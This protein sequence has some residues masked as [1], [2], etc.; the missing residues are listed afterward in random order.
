MVPNDFTASQGTYI[1]VV[2]IAY[3]DIDGEAVVYRFNEDNA[4]WQEISWTWSTMWADIGWLLPNGIIPGKEY[5]Y[6][7]RL[8]SDG[9]G[10]SEYSDEITGYA[11]RGNPVEI[12]SIER[13]IEG[14]DLQIKINWTNPNDLLEI[15]N[16]QNICYD[17]YRAE[18][19]DYSDFSEIKT[20]EEAVYNTNDI[21]DHWSYSDDDWLEPSKS[22]TY[23][24]VT[25][26]LYD[27]VDGNG[28]YR[29]YVEYSVDGEPADDGGSG[30][31]NGGN[32]VVE[33]TTTDLGQVL[34][35]SPG[36]VSDIEE[37]MVD[38]TLYLG[39]ITDASLYGKPALYRLNGSSW[40]N[41]WGS[42]PDVEYGEINFA[43]S[44]AGSYLAGVRDSLGVFHWDGAS[45][46][47]N[48]TPDNLGQDDSPAAISIEVLNNELYMAIEQHPQYDLQ[49]LK[50]NGS[51]WD[52]ISSN[53]NGI[54]ASG[55][56]Y[57]PKLDNINGT[58]YLHYLIDDVLY[59]RH[60]EGTGWASDLV[61]E[62][63]WLSDIELVKSGSQ[64]YFSC[65]SAST[66]FDGGVYR[67]DNAT[68]VTNLIPE[69]HEE[70]FTMGAFDLTA[71]ADGNLVVAS[72][73]YEFEDES[74]TSLISYPHLNVFDGT[75]WKT[76][77]GDFTD[78]VLPV[79]LT[80]SGN[81]IYYFYGDAATVNDVND[82]SSIKSKRLTK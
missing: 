28:D 5:R 78:G 17:I 9:P 67:V 52:T 49:V 2:H 29:D 55:S 75:E 15:K 40:Q 70:W 19:G 74:Q 35:A 51:T 57:T 44:N 73:K 61:W 69:E 79:A 41:V 12:T 27:F 58:L 1:G 60:L 64:L 63:E 7:M 47:S 43:V 14:N 6:K 81:D 48:L 62:Q 21:N 71:D 45:W 59:I 18:E 46:S 4:E 53:G 56:V 8:H 3:G 10:F 54:I 38:N 77:S 76:I 36:I 33:Y 37:K 23:K 16:L 31:G 26:Y 80:A 22:Y 11:F 42:V 32:P 65:G 30:N 72:M 13:Q 24:I 82:P 68:S 66:D 50:Y 34:A 25:R 20:L 39:A